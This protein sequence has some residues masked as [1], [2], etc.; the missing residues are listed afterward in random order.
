MNKKRLIAFCFSLLLSLGTTA[1]INAQGAPV[2]IGISPPLTHVVIQ[3]GKKALTTI[4]IENLG[5]LDAEI[6]PHFAD[7]LSDNESGEPIF[8]DSMSFPYIFIQDESIE[9]DKSFILNTGSSKQLLF[10]INLPETTLEK[11]YHF[12]LILDVNPVSSSLGESSET[13]IS[14]KI[15]SNFIVTVTR[16]PQD[17]GIIEMASFE[18]PIFLDSLSTVQAKVFVK[19]VGRNT[20]VTQGEFKIFNIF[21]KTVYQNE[22]LPQNILP[23]SIRQIFGSEQIIQ[24]GQDYKIEKPFKWKPL[25][26]LGPYRL[27]FTFH[28]PG[29]EPQ[30]FTHTVFALPV[31]LL[32]FVISIYILYLLYTKTNF[33]ILDRN[34]ENHQTESDSKS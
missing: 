4:M 5:T 31:S 3:P 20:T 29:Q 24:D 23:N 34:K 25:F 32:I 13:S 28:A 17:Q 8:Q 15:T 9:M 27:E 26:L 22:I 21:G 19:N 18:G 33:F 11:E 10:E 6:T 16:S 7:F 12:T 14:G 30:T 1:Q 2:N